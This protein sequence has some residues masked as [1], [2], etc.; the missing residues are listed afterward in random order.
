MNYNDKGMNDNGPP[1]KIKGWCW[2][3]KFIY[4]VFKINN[5]KKKI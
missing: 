4:G 5:N 2:K 3:E 1:R